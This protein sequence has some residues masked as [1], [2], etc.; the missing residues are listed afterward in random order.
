M[1][2]APQAE[3]GW[4]SGLEVAQRAA[5]AALRSG[6][7]AAATMHA[8]RAA[9]AAPQGVDLVPLRLCG[10]WLAAQVSIDAFKRGLA[11]PRPYK[12]FQD[13]RRRMRRWVK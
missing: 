5:Q 10:D 7:Y 11:R 6:D 9:K 12:G 1:L 13:W 3:I 8:E 4:G 2:G